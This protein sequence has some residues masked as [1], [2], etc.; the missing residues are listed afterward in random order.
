MRY[1]IYQAYSFLMLASQALALDVPSFGR[2]SDTEYETAFND[3]KSRL[4]D[5]CGEAIAADN[6]SNILYI[7]TLI[8]YNKDA[9]T[10]TSRYT[11][12]CFA[13]DHRNAVKSTIITLNYT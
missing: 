7:S 13:K 9:R 4:T 3:A 12:Y 5:Q 6:L 11:A 10:L 1:L 2:I 8:S